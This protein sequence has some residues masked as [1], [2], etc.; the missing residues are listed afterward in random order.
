MIKDFFNGIL[1]IIMAVLIAGVFLHYF[2]DTY[3]Q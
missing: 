1:S 3:I 2:C